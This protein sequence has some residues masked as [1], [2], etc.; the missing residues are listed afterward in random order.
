MTKTETTAGA[1][2]EML[3]FD[4]A[5]LDT[6]AASDKG[7]DLEL[8]HPTKKTPTGVFIRVLGKDGEV[9]RDHLR[10]AG[11]ERM[12][13]EAAAERK[14]QPL[15]PVTIEQAEEKALEVLVLCSVAWFTAKRDK[16]GNPIDKVPT[17][18]YK[19]ER[20]SFTANN[21]LRVYRE[22]IWVRKQVDTAI[23]D[24]ENFM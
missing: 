14:G 9:F 19:G 21:V 4:I 17:F 1:E 24:L 5:D 6:G 8:L 3:D 15:E 23:G 10:E 13:R 18:P 11:N 2:S 22:Q 7:F 16:D 12:R 20:L